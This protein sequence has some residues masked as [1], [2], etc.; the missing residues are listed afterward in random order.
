M[1]KPW[2]IPLLLTPIFLALLGFGL[3]FGVGT[4]RAEPPTPLAMALYSASPPQSLENV[5]FQSGAVL[6]EQMETLAFLPT[7]GLTAPPDVGKAL[8]F[9]HDF[10][11]SPAK[12][13][14]ADGSGGGRLAGIGADA[15][16]AA[17]L[18][19][20]LFGSHRPPPSAPS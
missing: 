6:P 5:A 8:D 16:L 11:I 10:P 13:K 20:T 2:R 1:K 19:T 7:Y 12:S 15:R 14:P 9:G 18:I 3:V 17:V 4:A